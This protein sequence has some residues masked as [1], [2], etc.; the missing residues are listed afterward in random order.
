MNGKRTVAKGSEPPPDKTNKT[1]GR[2]AGGCALVLESGV[3]HSRVSKNIRL[4]DLFSKSSMSLPAGT[5]AD[6]S[7]P[8]DIFFCGQK[9]NDIHAVF[10]DEIKEKNKNALGGHERGYAWVKAVRNVKMGGP[11]GCPVE[12]QF[13]RRHPSAISFVLMGQVRE[14][15]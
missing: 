9:S 4:F 11:A 3:Q 7:L 6:V 5:S 2:R 8:M 12:V 1:P 14:R 15:L 10:K 13:L